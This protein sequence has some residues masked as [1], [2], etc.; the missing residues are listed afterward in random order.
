MTE[1]NAQDPVVII[2]GGHNG[3]V[4]A[5]Y[6]AK[7]G[8][9]VLV[10]ESHEQVG[11]AAATREFAPGFKASCA[12]LNYLLDES[13]NTELDL[14]GN[15]LQMA[16]EELD[17]IA[18]S[19]NGNPLT[20]SSD[21]ITGDGISSADHEA[22]TESRRFMAKFASVIGALHNQVPPRIR[23][24]RDDLVTLAK[25]AFKVRQLGRDDM[26]E[27][28]RIAGI[29]VF[30]VL[31]ER[32]D[33]PQLKGALCMDAV[34]GAFSGPRSNNTVFAALHRMS[35]NNPGSAGAFSVPV[36][37]MGAITQ[38]LASAAVKAGADIRISSP[39][40]RILM[41][42]MQVSGV[43]LQN[44][45][46]IATATV[47]SNLDIHTTVMDL[48]GAHHVEAGFARRVDLVRSTGN[49]AKL[50]LALDGLPEFKGLNQDQLGQRL[51]IAPSPDY[52]E[53]AFNHCKYG[54]FSTQPVF[55]M[56]IPTIHDR[57]LAPDGKHVL[58]AVV[59]Y[60]P[61]N[62]KAGWESGKQAFTELVLSTLEEYAPGI[63]DQVLATELL[64]PE[65]MER[66]FGNHGGHWH[67][68]ELSLHQFLMLRPVPKSAQY[69]TPVDGLYLCGAGCHPGGGVMGSAGR[70]AAN[71]L[72][73][74]EGG[75]S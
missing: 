9:K 70:N 39:V 53:R 72:L 58:S 7:A 10:L 13:I 75:K 32:F 3:L 27:F 67:H 45:E 56:L 35:G 20:L 36:G 69:R 43:E 29:N 19:A 68:A 59:Q 74:A 64:T 26:R 49:A 63:S 6:L 18:L 62:L 47:I 2:G 60:A 42:G 38:A 55:E 54:E 48:L 21:R 14:A 23:Q 25:L 51:L 71:A 37:G 46:Q 5:A 52:V 50:H 1:M 40:R 15:G 41:D 44:G 61:R 65:D 28:L 31:A 17:T 12:H 57:S 34:L 8:R 11:G 30:D 66:E 22:Y 16:A 73:A 33:N 24:H 4:C